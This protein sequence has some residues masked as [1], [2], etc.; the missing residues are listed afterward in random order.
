MINGLPVYE[1]LT[2]PANRKSGEIGRREPG[3]NYLDRPGHRARNYSAVASE[4][5]PFG[6]LLEESSKLGAAAT[7]R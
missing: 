7:R 6:S 5:S 2:E 4:L 3:A 1:S